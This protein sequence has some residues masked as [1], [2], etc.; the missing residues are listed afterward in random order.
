MASKQ[1][2]EAPTCVVFYSLLVIFDYFF[3]LLSVED[4]GVDERVIRPE[5]GACTTRGEN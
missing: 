4:P 5:I 1:V 2:R 3:Y